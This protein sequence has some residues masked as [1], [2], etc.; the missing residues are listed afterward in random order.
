MAASSAPW[1]SLL[2]SIERR[3]SYDARF[4]KPVCLIAAIDS[5]LAGE[6]IPPRVDIDIVVDRFRSYV[7][8]AY[9]DRA[10]MGWRP[11]WHLSN[12]GVWTITKLGRR[13]EPAD[14][15]AARKPDSRGQ[16]MRRMDQAAIPPEALPAWNSS[17]ALADLRLALLE[18]LERDDATCRSMAAVLKGQARE[19]P[20]DLPRLGDSSSRPARVAGCGQGFQVS[21]EVRTAVERRAMAV[22]VA[23]LLADGYD[24]KDV[25]A[26]ESFD[27]LCTRTGSLVHVEVKGTIG[28]GEQ[29]ILTR[30]EVEFALANRATMILVVV[31]HIELERDEGGRI[32]A[33][34]GVPVVYREWAPAPSQLEPIAYMCRLNSGLQAKAVPEESLQDEDRSTL[35]VGRKAGRT[36]V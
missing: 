28:A 5:V 29:I 26:F 21:P 2:R 6:M 17:E 13:V 4:F 35:V 22:A 18:M 33:C 15:G 3:R 16:L 32:I 19:Q 7:A 8:P 24:V 9:P 1:A 30:G 12:D 14:F 20:I 36:A 34:N 10:D 27:L 23:Q 31:S 11:F 25:S